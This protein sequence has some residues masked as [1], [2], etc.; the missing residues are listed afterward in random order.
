MRNWILVSLNQKFR[1]G[2]PFLIERS[3]SINRRKG[4]VFLFVEQRPSDEIEVRRRRR[5]RRRRRMAC[6]GGG[7]ITAV[8]R[9]ELIR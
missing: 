7:A 3:F 9:R 8:G 6:G 4:E 5:R 2:A 1:Y